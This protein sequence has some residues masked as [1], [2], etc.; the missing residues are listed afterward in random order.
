MDKE[1]PIDPIP[2]EKSDHEEN[3]LEMRHFLEE[4]NYNDDLLFKSIDLNL[5]KY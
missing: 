2:L 4:N 5:K 1:M 3:I